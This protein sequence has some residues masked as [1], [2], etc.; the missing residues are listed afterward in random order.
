MGP[1]NKKQQREERYRTEWYWTSWKAKSLRLNHQHINII[2]TITLMATSTRNFAKATKNPC[3]PDKV[4]QTLDL[5]LKKMWKKHCVSKSAAGTK[6]IVKEIRT[7][8]RWKSLFKYFTPG[9]LH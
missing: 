8:F 4:E 9:T 5:G 2:T 1:G 3:L 7:K 6:H